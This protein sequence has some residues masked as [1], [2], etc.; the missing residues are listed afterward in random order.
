MLCFCLQRIREL[1]V[2]K[3][4]KQLPTNFKALYLNENMEVRFFFKQAFPHIDIFLRTVNQRTLYKNTQQMFLFNIF[5]LLPVVFSLE[6][7]NNQ[8][9]LLII[10]YCMWCSYFPLFDTKHGNPNDYIN[11]YIVCMLYTHVCNY[12]QCK[13]EIRL[14]MKSNCIEIYSTELF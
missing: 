5:I 10:H 2:A 12:N 3:F 14:T 13:L 1:H 6:T 9:S 4:T 8:N 11:I 7:I